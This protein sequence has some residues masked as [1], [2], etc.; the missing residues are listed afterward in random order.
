MK[1]SYKNPQQMLSWSFKVTYPV[2]F[3]PEELELAKPDVEGTGLQVAIWMPHHDDVNGPTQRRRVHLLVQRV[4]AGECSLHVVHP[5]ML[6]ACVRT[7]LQ[8]KR[9]NERWSDVQKV[10]L[11]SNKSRSS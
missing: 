10:C 8:G 5:S 6:Q 1:S 3:G 2:K 4:H 9:E 7:W 11:F